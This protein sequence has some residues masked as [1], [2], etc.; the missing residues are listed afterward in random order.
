MTVL[1]RILFIVCS[2]LFKM[3]GSHL[4]VSAG[5]T[6]SVCVT[7]NSSLKIIR[8]LYCSNLYTTSYGHFIKLICTD[9][10]ECC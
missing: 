1:L 4:P 3:S 9:L 5:G 6:V 10:A 7:V 2:F 8:V